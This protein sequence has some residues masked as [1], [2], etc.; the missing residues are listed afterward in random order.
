MS[1]RKEA[2]SCVSSAKTRRLFFFRIA[3]IQM[4]HYYC[5]TVV[6][7]LTGS[8]HLLGMPTAPPRVK[9]ATRGNSRRGKKRR[10]YNVLRKLAVVLRKCMARSMGC[11]AVKPGS[12]VVAESQG[13]LIS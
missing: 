2:V 8:H 4:V 5:T 1:C 11:G 6:F 12:T 3:R 10:V 9:G 13:V 7:E